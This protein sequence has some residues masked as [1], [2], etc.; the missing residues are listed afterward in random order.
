MMK[1]GRRNRF[2]L[3]AVVT[4]VF[5]VNRFIIID[6]QTDNAVIAWVLVSTSIDSTPSTFSIETVHQTTGTSFPQV[7]RN[8]SAALTPT[9]SSSAPLTTTEIAT[10]NKAV[11][12]TTVTPKFATTTKNR[13]FFFVETSNT[14]HF[15]AREACAV[16]SVARLHPSN[17]VRLLYIADTFNLSNPLV[18]LLLKYKNV[19]FSHVDLDTMMKGSPLEPWIEKR[20]WE[21][22]PF[23]VSHLSD[24]M[25]TLLMWKYGGVYLDLDVVALRPLDD[26]TN[27]I[28]Q[29]S[30]DYVAAGVLMFEKNHP[31]V[32]ASIYE[33][34]ST[35]SSYRWGYNGP[36]LYLRVLR[37]LCK[38][39][40]FSDLP[41]EVKNCSGVL[42]LPPSAFYPIFYPA[43]RKYFSPKLAADTIMQWIQGQSYLIHIWNKLA[44]NEPLVIGSGQPYDLA[45][46]Y[47]CPSVYEHMRPIKEM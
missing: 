7:T 5:L 36:E 2:I 28:G 21:K 23:N 32:N 39:K 27:A 33:L 9:S 16:E 20:P 30:T 6:K 42:I 1:F 41:G 31:A 14:S 26:L 35:Y 45:A 11:F 38:V 25:R 37:Q 34:L 4:A 47:C 3:I 8:D 17:P 46:K 29:Q 22:S 13:T 40:N 10:T 12:E 15:T 24:V 44:E 19:R 43:W 18:N